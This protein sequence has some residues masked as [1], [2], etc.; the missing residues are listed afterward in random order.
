MT[1]TNAPA[2]P[3]DAG[4]PAFTP[5]ANSQLADELMAILEQFESKMPH[6]EQKHPSTVPFVRAHRFV[7]TEFLGST[8]NAVAENAALQGTGK[9][10]PAEGREVL[11]FLEA[12]A[13]VR[14]KLQTLSN[15][16]TFTMEA[17]RASLAASCLQV[18]TIAKGVVRDPGSA[19]LVDHIGT[20]QHDLGRSR[21]KK[22]VKKEPGGAGGSGTTPP[23]TPAPVSS[24]A[25]AST[26][27]QK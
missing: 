15:A 8:I 16:V 4:V 20:M 7:P 1:T 10:D 14:Q 9:L 22:R 13:A 5:T 6:F 25:P 26:T 2:T 3:P 24:P 18:Y 19:D 17:R 27:N 21:P 11:Q 12:F 23:A